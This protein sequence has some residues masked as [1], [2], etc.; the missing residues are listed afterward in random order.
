[1]EGSSVNFDNRIMLA[2]EPTELFISL[3]GKVVGYPRGLDF[4]VPRA[5]RGNCV[6][7]HE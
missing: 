5:D 7:K 2:T 1:M 3:C 4:M 6:G